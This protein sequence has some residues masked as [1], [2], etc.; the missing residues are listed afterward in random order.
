MEKDG[1][2]SAGG[3]VSDIDLIISGHTHTVLGEAVKV[4]IHT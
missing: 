3:R 1:G 2:L 4:G